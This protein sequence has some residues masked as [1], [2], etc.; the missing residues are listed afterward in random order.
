MYDTMI[1][2][3]N[4]NNIAYLKNISKLNEDSKRF[5]VAV[6]ATWSKF[7]GVPAKNVCTTQKTI[8]SM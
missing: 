6:N 2:I 7:W 8:F 1:I 4:G 3:Y 5:K